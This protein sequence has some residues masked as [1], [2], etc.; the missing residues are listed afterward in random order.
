MLIPWVLVQRDVLYKHHEAGLLRTGNFVVAQALAQ[1]VTAL[2]ETLLVTGVVFVLVPTVS[3]SAPDA[4]VVLGLLFVIGLSFNLSINGLVKLCAYCSPGPVV[5][6]LANTLLISFLAFYSGFV[7]SEAN[8]PATLRYLVFWTSPMSWA[9]RAAAITVFGSETFAQ[10]GR[11][12]QALAQ[13]DIRTERFWVPAGIAYMLALW[14]VSVACQGVVLRR[15]RYVSA[16]GGGAASS[17][18]SD[19]PE[20]EEE[21]EE[22]E[23][24]E[25]D[26]GAAAEQEQEREQKRA[27]AVA[28]RL[29]SVLPCPRVHLAFRDMCY[30]I[31]VKGRYKLLVD[32]VSGV[33]RSGRLCAIVGATGA[34]KTTTL[35]VLAGRKTVGVQTGQVLVN[36]VEVARSAYLRMVG[37]CEQQD[38]H[39]ATATVREAVLFSAALRLPPELQQGQRDEFVDEILVTLQLTPLAG[40]LAGVKGKGGLSV[41]HAKRLT[42]A[43][44]MA[45]NP[46][47]L[48]LDE[49]TSGLDST[50]AQATVGAV[51]RLS[52]AGRTVLCT[53]HQPSRE[54]FLLFDDIL[55]LQKG[56]RVAYHGR[57]DA[58]VAYFAA[59]ERNALPVP[60]GEFNP[61]V[62]ALDVIGAGVHGQS[63]LPSRRPREGSVVGDYDYAAHFAASPESRA[64][65]AAIEELQ[66]Q[67]QAQSHSLVTGERPS[68]FIVTAHVVH[69]WCVVTARSPA[70]HLLRAG[71]MLAITTLVGLSLAHEGGR[72]T[73]P[74]AS[75]FVGA[76]FFAL[77]LSGFLCSTAGLPLMFEARNVYYRERSARAYS[78]AAYVLG[79]TAAETPSLLLASLVAGTALY[80][81]MGLL[82]DAAAF[83]WFQAVF[84]LYNAACA[85]L[86][87]LFSSV[88]SVLP[89]ATVLAVASTS[90]FSL[91]SGFLISYGNCPAWLRWLYWLSPGSYALNGLVL[92]QLAGCPCAVDAQ[93]SLLANFTCNAQQACSQTCDAEALGCEIVAVGPLPPSGKLFHTT[94]MQLMEQQFG[95]VERAAWIDMVVLLAFCL[96][97]RVCDAVAL[98]RLSMSKR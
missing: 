62:Y 48:F 63:R 32:R 25:H 74:T 6:L 38:N 47:I 1:V 57:V 50:T 41:G 91:F 76:M 36:G 98:A 34:G 90:A 84:F 12:A 22:E 40:C 37:Y 39:L 11:G 81:A 92:S 43:V 96:V 66:T 15:V 51:K 77:T 71:V 70:Y 65:A 13:F 28:E 7:L 79:S 95:I 49:P 27:A 16:G 18:S 23:E 17:G 2:P 60:E 56:G 24:E 72:T 14:L 80:F 83:M 78:A 9:L 5:A 97:L 30:Q 46:A 64:V 61:S 4:G 44:E 54:L 55:L 59:I 45:A 3:L 86:G 94:L 67:A 82:H 19:S 75:A 73:I 29:S 31:K 42:V 53:I 88:A 21:E 58:M 35:D 20:K 52:R 69:R 26:G 89:L 68:A 10:D 85:C 87:M 8:Q 33:A 93:S